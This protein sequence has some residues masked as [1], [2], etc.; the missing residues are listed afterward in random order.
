MN[1][2]HLSKYHYIYRLSFGGDRKTH[3]EK[4]PIAYSNQHYIYIIEPGADELR[5]LI[6][7]PT[8]EWGHGEVY[9]SIDSEVCEKITEYVSNQTANRAYNPHFVLRDFWFLIDDPEPLKNFAN[10]LS[11]VD[12]M[13]CYLLM[14]KDKKEK[15]ISRIEKDRTQAKSELASINYKLSKLEK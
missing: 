12:L 13:K 6:L 10:H 1:Y 8:W 5:K 9:T 15:E 4:F 2:K 11:E 14:E 3:V 7:V